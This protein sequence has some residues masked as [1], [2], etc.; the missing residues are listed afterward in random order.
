MA[1]RETLHILKKVMIEVALRS[2]PW[3]MWVSVAKITN[4]FIQGLDMLHDN[5]ASM[6]LE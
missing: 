3:Q 6:D 2:Q 4:D 5:N 1:S